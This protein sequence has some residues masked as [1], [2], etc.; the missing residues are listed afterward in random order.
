MIFIEREPKRYIMV[1]SALVDY[2]SINDM[3]SI[4]QIKNLL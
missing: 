3:A 1:T 2:I 4:F